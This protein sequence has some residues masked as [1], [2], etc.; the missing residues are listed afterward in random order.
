LFLIYAALALG[1]DPATLRRSVMAFRAPFD[2][3][4]SLDAFDAFVG[5]YDGLNRLKGITGPVA[6]SFTLDG[7]SN[8]TARTGLFWPR[9]S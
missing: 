4:S 7:A 9:G 8:I 2:A 6:E 3:L 5:P 1:R